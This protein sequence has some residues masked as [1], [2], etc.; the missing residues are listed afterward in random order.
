VNRAKRN[1]AVD[2]ESDNVFLARPVLTVTFSGYCEASLSSLALR[3]LSLPRVRTVAS[4]DVRA[5]IAFEDP[6]VCVMIRTSFSSQTQH[7]LP[8][9]VDVARSLHGA[10][11]ISLWSAFHLVL[12]L[13]LPMETM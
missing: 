8:I 10:D 4:V 12:Q 3:T 9:T 13:I 7:L 6:H 1:S 11:F 2:F 5:Q